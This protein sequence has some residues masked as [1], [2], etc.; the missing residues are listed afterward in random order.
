MHNNWVVKIQFAKNSVGR[1][2]NGGKN[3]ITNYRKFRVIKWCIIKILSKNSMGQN[4]YEWK[5]VQLFPIISIMEV[6]VLSHPCLICHCQF[7]NFSEVYFSSSCYKLQVM[8]NSYKIIFGDSN[9]MMVR[10]KR[11]KERYCFIIFKSLVNNLQH[12]RIYF[13]GKCA[14]VY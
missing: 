10:Q 1:K 14:V 13:E 12:I 7:H 8:S 4:L 3:S 5:S 9:N 11:K 2:S 6:L